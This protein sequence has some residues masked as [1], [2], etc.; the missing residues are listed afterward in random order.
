M[1]DDSFPLFFS[2]HD[3]VYKAA[4]TVKQEVGEVSIL[5]NNAAVVTGRSI[6]S[7]PDELIDRTFKVNLMAQF[8]VS[9]TDLTKGSHCSRMSCSWN[10]IS[11]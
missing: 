3:A 10:N 5:I 11:V 4:Q 9:K 8:W 1:N 6:L 2:E 7:S